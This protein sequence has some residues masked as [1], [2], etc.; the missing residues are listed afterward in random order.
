[1]FFYYD[2]FEEKTA[3]CGTP[4]IVGYCGNKLNE[5]EKEGKNLFKALCASCH[6]LDKKLIGPALG[7]IQMD[8]IMFFNYVTIKNSVGNKSHQPYFYQLSI[9]NT[10]DV[11]EYLK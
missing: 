8:S 1:M 3:Y 7:A 5:N 2:R 10:N 9:K 4:D 11:F 6:K